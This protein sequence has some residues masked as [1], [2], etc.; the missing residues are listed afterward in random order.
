MLLNLDRREERR[1][2]RSSQL[3]DISHKMIGRSSISGA[4]HLLPNQSSSGVKMRS[5]LSL[6]GGFDARLMDSWCGEGKLG[7]AKLIGHAV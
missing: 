4:V 2:I 6:A 7:V 3:Q 1:V 5:K